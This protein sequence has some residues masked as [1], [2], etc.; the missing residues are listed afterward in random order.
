MVQAYYDKLEELRSKLLAT[1]QNSIFT[2]EKM[3]RENISEVYTVVCN[4]ETRPSNLQKERTAVLLNQLGDAE[5]LNDAII[6]QF[7]AKVKALLLKEKIDKLEKTEVKQKG[8][9]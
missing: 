1:K 8:N 7:D 4:Q 3:L 5:K 2:N 9:L 6:N